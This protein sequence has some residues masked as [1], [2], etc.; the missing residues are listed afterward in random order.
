MGKR[1]IV[2]EEE[3]TKKQKVGEDDVEEEDPDDRTEEG[4]FFEAV[5]KDDLNKIK[6]LEKDEANKIDWEDLLFY[7]VQKGRLEIYDHIRPK[8]K[9]FEASSVIWYDK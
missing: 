1:E 9:K 2:A 7:A 3:T 4:P 6:E 5:T 8:L